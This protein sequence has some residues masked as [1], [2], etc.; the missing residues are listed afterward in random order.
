L[1]GKRQGDSIAHRFESEIHGD[2][3]GYGA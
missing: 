1:C 3:L 2:S